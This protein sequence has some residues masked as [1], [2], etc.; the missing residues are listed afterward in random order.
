MGRGVLFDVKLHDFTDG[1]VGIAMDRVRVQ[2]KPLVITIEDN[3]FNAQLRPVLDLL[4][5]KL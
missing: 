2:V 1:H 5:E 4:Q 3:G